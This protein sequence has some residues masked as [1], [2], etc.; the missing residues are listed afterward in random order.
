MM[1][2]SGMSS[3]NRRTSWTTFPN[4]N[5]G[6]CESIEAHASENIMI[7]TLLR[8]MGSLRTHTAVSVRSNE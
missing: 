3:R 7:D 8:L 1:K 4:L 2:M 6:L 5:L